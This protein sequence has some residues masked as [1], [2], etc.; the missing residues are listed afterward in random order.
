MELKP[1]AD[2]QV[3]VA[4]S[5][6]TALTLWA[7]DV[8]HIDLNDRSN[9]RDGLQLPLIS[10]GDHVSA[11]VQAGHVYF[12]YMRSVNASQQ[13][14]VRLPQHSAPAADASGNQANQT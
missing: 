3:T 11:A 5:S 7:Q 13:I 12:L 1:Q 14:E 10:Q 2:G 6:P 9:V 4:A 8:T